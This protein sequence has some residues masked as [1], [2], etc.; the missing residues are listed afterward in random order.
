MPLPIIS[1]TFSNGLSSIPYAYPIA[2]TASGIAAIAL[3]KRYFGGAIN[4]SERTM[5]SKVIMITGGTSGVGASIVHELASRG[6]QIIILTQHS[7]SD[8]FVVDYIEDVRNSTNN[9]LVYAEQVDLSS[10]HSVR[11]FATKWIDNTPPRRLDMVILCGNTLTPP[12]SPEL[13]NTSDRLNREWQVNY[14]AN[15]HLLSILSPALRAQPPDRDVRVIFA[16]C[17]SYIRAE[18]DFETLEARTSE[19]TQGSSTSKAKSSVKG[20]IRSGSKSSSSMYATSKLALLIF[21]RSYQAHLANYD[22]SNRTKKQ[23]ARPTNSRVLVVDPGF[24]RTP[25]TRRWLTGG[26]L[27]G[28]LFYLLTWPIWWLILKSPQQGAQSFLLA[29]MEAGLSAVGET[30][31]DRQRRIVGIQ[32]GRLIKECKQREVLRK[33]VMDDK[34]AEKLWK[35]SQEQIEKTE[36]ASALRRAIE[37]GEKQEEAKK[38]QKPVRGKKEG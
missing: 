12:C 10:L 20:T 8:P 7:P 32:G 18:L 33:E 5:H 24:S 16:T 17:S 28:L 6:A 37:K 35:F 2:K 30:D 1:H 36:K 25:G 22:N 34:I 9:S 15:F 26:S 19:A 21:A 4:Q 38:K 11:R 13:Q 14:L 27:L 29:A 3:L 23:A 31:E